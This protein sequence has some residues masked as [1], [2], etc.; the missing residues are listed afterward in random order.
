M[1]IAGVAARARRPPAC[2]AVVVVL[3]LAAAGLASGA[4]PQLEITAPPELG[5][6]AKAVAALAEEDFSEVLVLTGRVGFARPVRVVL[7]PETSKLAHDTPSW[8]AGYARSERRLIVLFPGRVPTYP[9]RS[10]RSLLRHEIAHLLVWE[11]SRGRPVPRWLNEGIAA[12]AAR[13]WGLEDRA[14]YATAVL[15]R[16][17]RTTRAIDRGFSASAAEA[18]RSYALAAAFVR[19]IRTEFGA[20]APARVLDGIANGLD[21]EAAFERATG[22]PLKQVEQSFFRDRAL[23]TFWL[24]FLTSTGAL[25]MAVTLLALVAIVRRRARNRAQHEEWQAEEGTALGG[26]TDGP[27]HPRG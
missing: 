20:D 3:V 13:E 27:H 25:W 15:G 6:T 5:S 8:V 26:A 7:V 4:G 2:S 16:G 24:P 9:D 1:T 19:F 10:M 22:A 21:V 14:R 11:A 12:V 17:P 23:V 18:R